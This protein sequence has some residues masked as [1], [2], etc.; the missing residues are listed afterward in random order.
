MRPADPIFVDLL[1]TAGK[2]LLSLINCHSGK[3]R[4]RLVCIAS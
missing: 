3:V 4:N 2:Q 1:D